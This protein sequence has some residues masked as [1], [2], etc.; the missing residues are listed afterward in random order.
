M[1]RSH[2][3]GVIDNMPNGRIKIYHYDAKE[4]KSDFVQIINH[5][6]DI[7]LTI[8]EPILASFSIL[9]ISSAAYVYL[10]SG[11]ITLRFKVDSQYINN[12]Y[13]VF[14][15]VIDV[16]GSQSQNLRERVLNFWKE[17]RNISIPD[18]VQ[19]KFLYDSIYQFAKEYPNHNLSSETLVQS[20]FLSYKQAESIFNLLS[21][22]Q[23][24]KFNLNGV[25]KFLMRLKA[26]DIGT[27]AYLPPQLDS[28]GSRIDLVTLTHKYTLIDFWASW[29]GPCRKA[30]PEL[31]KIYS[32]FNKMGLQIISISLDDT[33]EN[34]IRALRQERL[35]WLQ[36]SE[37]KGFY[38]EIA[39]YYH[40]EYIPFNL[41]L[42]ESGK[43]VGKAL[44]D[45]GLR[46]KL[47][48]LLNKM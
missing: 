13:Y 39:K 6:F 37:L 17:I 24:A 22:E 21:N 46:Q 9:P 16:I 18:S 26:T 14:L 7:N 48:T 40:L 45:S 23:R 43:I 35:P 11:Q 47:S 4:P 32:E 5:K 3:S 44:S 36:V 12:K 28:I 30:F 42:D 8:T 33:H 19:N 1:L 15:N 2:I 25:E 34:W 31:K 29:C 20:E 10:D 41:L 38:A 27:I